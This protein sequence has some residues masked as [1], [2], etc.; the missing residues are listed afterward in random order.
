MRT[1]PRDRVLNI[2]LT[3][4]TYR[5][6]QKGRHGSNLLHPDDFTP[7]PLPTAVLT[8]LHDKAGNF[9]DDADV[10]MFRQ[11]GDYIVFDGHD[12]GRMAVV[13]VPGDG[14]YARYDRRRHIRATAAAPAKAIWVPTSE[15]PATGSDP[16][17]IARTMWRLTVEDAT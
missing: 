11:D 3:P 17:G 16:V 6:D 15:W 9:D 7:E 14:L 13:E 10:P 1:L 12:T 4:I 5:A 8:A 2:L